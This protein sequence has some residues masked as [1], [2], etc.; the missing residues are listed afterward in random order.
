VDFKIDQVLDLEDAT[1]VRLDGDRIA[2]IGKGLASYQ[3]IDCGLFLCAPT[4]FSA[5]ERA[6]R[7]GR[8][9][10]SD[11]MRELGLSR[12]FRAF[13]IGRRWWQDVDTPEMALEAERR[14]ERA[15]RTPRPPGP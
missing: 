2:D 8:L 15:C 7:A 9:S 12:P 13:D 14:L 3:A 1:K 5:L 6:Q 10:L 4:I 11:G